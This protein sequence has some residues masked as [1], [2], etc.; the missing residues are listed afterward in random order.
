[1]GPTVWIPPA[2]PGGGGPGGAA[3]APGRLSGPDSRLL[4]V[5]S[6]S[7]EGT[8]G[9]PPPVSGDSVLLQFIPIVALGVGQCRRD[10]PRGAH[11]ITPQV[12]SGHVP[13]THRSRAPV[14]EPTRSD[15]AATPAQS[16]VR[17]LWVM[18]DYP[19]NRTPPAQQGAVV[20]LAALLAHILS[21]VVPAVA[22][23]EAIAGQPSISTAAPAEET[24]PPSL[25]ET[26]L[27]SLGGHA[28]TSPPPGAGA[29]PTRG[30]A[31]PG[32]LEADKRLGQ[33]VPGDALSIM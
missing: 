28:V 5:L 24:A 33:P 12:V 7:Q 8:G 15:E 1:M 32:T 31:D 6:S 13:A 22:A 19:R 26:V 29:I 11:T 25:T 2:G 27:Y 17:R 4:G 30:G 14:P 23:Q 3:P 20:A 16:V 9:L 18:P 21:G 10:T